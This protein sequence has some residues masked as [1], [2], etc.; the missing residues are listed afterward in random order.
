MAASGRAAWRRWG[1][2]SVAGDSDRGVGARSGRSQVSGSSARHRPGARYDLSVDAEW[3]PDRMSVSADRYLD[4]LAA[5]VWDLDA[6][7]VDMSP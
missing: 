2:E 4:H 5:G 1:P 3:S 6:A 7:D